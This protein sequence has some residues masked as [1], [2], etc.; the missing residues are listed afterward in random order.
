M[1]SNRFTNFVNRVVNSVLEENAIDLTSFFPEYGVLDGQIRQNLIEANEDKRRTIEI[2]NGRIEELVNSLDVPAG[3]KEI[4]EQAQRDKQ[5]A[6][7][8]HVDAHVAMLS[9]KSALESEVA[10]HKKTTLKLEEEKLKNKGQDAGTF[11]LRVKVE[12]LELDNTNLLGELEL[13]Q[14]RVDGL[15][16]RITELKAVANTKLVEKENLLDLIITARD[17]LNEA[18]EEHDTRQFGMDEWTGD[19]H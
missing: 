18:L 8:A 14:K 15:E 4:F 1:G 7:R 13:K 12:S 11:G 19:D 16:R 5:Q 10:K 17:K 6:Q 3:A 9:A 2:L